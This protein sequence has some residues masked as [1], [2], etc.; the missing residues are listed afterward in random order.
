VGALDGKESSHL[1]GLGKPQTKNITISRKY[2]N[3]DQESNPG[4]LDLYTGV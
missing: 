2:V 3:L 1:K 4:I